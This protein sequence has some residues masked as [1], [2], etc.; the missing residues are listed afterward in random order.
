MAGSRSTNLS[1]RCGDF[2]F[3]TNSGSSAREFE[4]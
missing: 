3:F 2:L 1:E 4:S